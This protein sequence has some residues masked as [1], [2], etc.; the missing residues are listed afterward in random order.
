MTADEVQYAL[1]YSQNSPF[2]YRSHYVVPNVHWGL[3]FNHELDLLVVSMVTGIGTE[4]EIK[5]SRG[6]LKRDLEKGHHHFDKRLRQLY[7]A[8]PRELYDAFFEYVP[9]EA[10]IIVI[11]NDPKAKWEHR[12]YQCSI[13]RN[14]KPQP[15]IPFKPKEIEQLLRLGNM[16]YWSLFGKQFKRRRNGKSSA[17]NP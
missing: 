6:D 3:G 8:G 13:V 2:Y 17:A 1:T 15:F 10:G 16:R 7:F 12:R 9:K 5:V 11:Y 14:A 4:V